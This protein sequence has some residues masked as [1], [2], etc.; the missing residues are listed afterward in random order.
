[1]QPIAS[2][3]GPASDSDSDENDYSPFITKEYWET[4]V[5]MKRNIKC[6]AKQLKAEQKALHDHFSKMT[7]FLHCKELDSDEE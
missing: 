5:K 7:M 3:L 4:M 6:L 2:T 1:M